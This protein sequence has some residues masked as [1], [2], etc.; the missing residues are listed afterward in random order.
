MNGWD[1]SV[2]DRDLRTFSTD[3]QHTVRMR[4]QIPEECLVVGESG[5]HSPE[6]VRLLAE[7]GVDAI[8]VGESLMAKRDIGQAVETLLSQV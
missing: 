2:S 4:R 7:A 5:I 8:L 3:L 1:D 6:D